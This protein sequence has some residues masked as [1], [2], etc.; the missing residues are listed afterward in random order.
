MQ[1][2]KKSDLPTTDGLSKPKQKELFLQ[3][4]PNN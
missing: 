2:F 1:D 4:P 3:R